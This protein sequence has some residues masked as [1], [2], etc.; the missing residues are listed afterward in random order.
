MVRRN[1]AESLD[2]DVDI[3]EIAT[4]RRIRSF[5]G[6]RDQVR[7]A[8]FSPDGRRLATASGTRQPGGRFGW[9]FP[10]QA[11]HEGTGVRAASN[12]ALPIDGTP[13]FIKDGWSVR[14]PVRAE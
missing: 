7:D 10:D 4:C 5:G 2:R 8:A 11:C 6:H 1:P 12:N 9:R 3:W 13:R 14:L